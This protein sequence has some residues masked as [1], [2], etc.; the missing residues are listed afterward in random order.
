MYGGNQ[1]LLEFTMKNQ[2]P[3]NYGQFLGEISG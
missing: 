3:E 1:H 2:N